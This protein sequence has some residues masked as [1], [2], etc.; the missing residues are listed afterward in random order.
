MF[1]LV[2]GPLKHFRTLK[3]FQNSIRRCLKRE[4]YYFRLASLK[5]SLVGMDL[6]VWQSI[7]MGVNGGCQS[8]HMEVRR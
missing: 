2:S 4:I 5:K 7:H 1:S 3:T 6:G 8:A